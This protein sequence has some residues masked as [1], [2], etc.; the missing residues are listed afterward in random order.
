[1]IGQ[2]YE[3]RRDPKE[4]EQEQ[5]QKALKNWMDMNPDLV[6]QYLQ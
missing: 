3:L 2:T 6:E 5:A 1:M 4:R